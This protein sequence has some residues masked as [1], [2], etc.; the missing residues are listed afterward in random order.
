MVEDWIGD[1]HAKR[2]HTLQKQLEFC[3]D[4]YLRTILYCFNRI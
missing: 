1:N 4:K 3:I 2:I